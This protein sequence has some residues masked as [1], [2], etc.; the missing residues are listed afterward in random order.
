[1]QEKNNQTSECTLS[2]LLNV[3][4][5]AVSKGSRILLMAS[6]HPDQLVEALV[7]PGRIDINIHSILLCIKI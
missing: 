3:L 6:N 2:G 4:D 5:G 1:M 7:R